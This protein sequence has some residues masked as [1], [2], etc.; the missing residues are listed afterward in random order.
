MLAERSHG[1]VFYINFNRKIKRKPL[2]MEIVKQWSFMI[3]LA[4]VIATC[5][6]F[7]IPPGKIGKAMNM[8]LGLFVI[9]IF[10]MPFSSKYHNLKSVFK[11]NIFENIPKQKDAE[12]NKLSESLNNQIMDSTKEKIKLI[13]LKNLKN[14]NIYPKK[15]E[16]IMDKDEYERIVI[17]ECKISV[18]SN[19]IYLKEKIKNEIENKLNIKTEVNK[20]EI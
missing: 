12:K 14:I 5:T 19:D 15:V 4:S 8:V 6:E 17:N 9:T 2:Y 16:V 20:D 10:F 3:C 1:I 7:L 11:N 13:I 18:N